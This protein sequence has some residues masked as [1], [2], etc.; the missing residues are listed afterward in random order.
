MATSAQTNVDSDFQKA[1]GLQN[2][3]KLREAGQLYRQIVARDPEHFI[4]WHN[5]G[6]IVTAESGSGAAVPLL[7]NAVRIKPDFAEGHNSLG[8]AY[9]AL[10]LT[11]R[12]EKNLRRAVAE[13]P[14]NAVFHYNF[15]N[16]ML[17]LQRYDEAEKAYG[18]A[19]AID[20]NYKEA[21]V[22]RGNALRNLSRRTESL[23]MFERSL[24][25]DPDFAHGHTGAGNLLRDLGENERALKHYRRAIEC[26]PDLAITHFNFANVLYDLGQAAGAEAAF[27]RAIEL[28]PTNA[29]FYRHLTQVVRLKPD[30]ILVVAMQE[31][32]ESPTNTEW[33]RMNFGF[34]LG[35]V[36]DRAGL[37]DQAFRYFAEAN[38]LKRKTTDHDQGFELA[39]LAATRKIFAPQRFA[40][41]P[42]SSINDE[43]PV[44]VVGMMRSGTTLTEQILASH[45]DVAGAGESRLVQ[46]IV[47]ARTEK[48]GKVYPDSLADVTADELTD[49]GR[50]YLD[51][52]RKLHGS[53]PLRI[54]DKM[55]QN[56]IY[57]GLIRLMLPKARFIWLK[58]DPMDN[59]FSIFSILFT[60][61][62][63]Y[64][65]DLKEIGAYYRYSEAMMEHWR[66]LFPD[67][68][69]V[70]QYETLIEDSEAEVRRL[71]DFC[72]LPFHENCLNFH[73]NERI[74][75]T[76]SAIQ[77]R[78]GFNR[79]SIQ[80]WKPYEHH[81]R[82]LKKALKEA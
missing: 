7:W 25:I 4:A 2:A 44:F 76:A 53:K 26:A 24:E 39:R 35:M 23:A 14:S 40:A 59:C 71:L 62:H 43:T 60:Q 73:K 18:E 82:D 30:D 11:E 72:G 67:Q 37:H 33:A 45:P 69:H 27:R 51:Q 28:D 46:E 77:V 15:G 16:L 80:R 61:G 3:G 8:N 31:G 58:R 20:R 38:R 63:G 78:E 68:I 9:Q 47:N 17:K 66:K 1:F 21:C 50:S 54:V 19:L 65:Y 10:N 48:T 12:A 64:A 75:R 5:L 36:F 57:A 49:M 32:F 52:M 13:E 41:H 55:P 42:T 22:N 29:D 81:L 74:V 34:A 56:F 6:L 79:R 70:Q